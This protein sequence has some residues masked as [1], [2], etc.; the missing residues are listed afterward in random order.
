MQV[1]GAPSACCLPF[2]CALCVAGAAQAARSDE[3]G[4][5]GPSVFPGATID[6][7]LSAADQDAL[8]DNGQR[9]GDSPF[10]RVR[11]SLSADI[12]VNDRL[13]VFN[14]TFLNPSSSTSV[15]SFLRSYLRYNVI[16]SAN[17]HLNLE[18]GKIPTPFGHFTQRAYSE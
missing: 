16:A 14:R 18:I 10:S 3:G 15:A 11:V 6:F 2:L 9:R 8:D 12:A 1:F 4:Q 13:S 5:A 7:Q 17:G